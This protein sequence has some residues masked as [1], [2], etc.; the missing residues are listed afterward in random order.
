MGARRRQ[1]A[2]VLRASASCSFIAPRQ[3][4]PLAA[5]D[6]GRSEASEHLQVGQLTWEEELQRGSGPRLAPL[7]RLIRAL[8]V[9]CVSFKPVY[10]P[11]SK[12]AA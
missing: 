12:G 7:A 8:P 3:P 4:R 2:G 10:C 11:V 1:E 9:R 5:A 6:V